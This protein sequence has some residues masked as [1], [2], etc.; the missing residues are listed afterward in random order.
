MRWQP[1]SLPDGAY[2]DASKPFSAQDVVN[3]M[4][5]RAEAANTRSAL[6]LVD[7]PGLREFAILGDGP[8]RGALVINGKAFIVS[9]TTLYKLVSGTEAQIIGTIP[10]RSRVSMTCNQIDGGNE[11]VIAT[12]GDTYV[13]NTLTGDFARVTDSGHHG[14]QVCDYI[15]A[16]VVGVETHRRF[17]QNSAE[18][19]A[20]TYDALET[21]EGESKPDLLVTLIVSENRVVVFSEK[22]VEW[23][24]LSQSQE[25]IDN[26]ILFTNSGV[27]RDR[28]CAGKHALALIDGAVVFLGDD[29]SLYELRGYDP[30]RISTMAVENA[31]ADYDWSKAFATVY[32]DRGHKVFYLTFP[33]GHTWGY[34]FATRKFHRRQSKGMDRWRLNTLFKWDGQWYGGAHNAGTLYTLDWDYMLEGCD[35]H[36]RTVRTGVLHDEGDRVTL[37]AL[38]VEFDSGSE[39]STCSHADEIIPETPPPEVPVEEFGI[40]YVASTTASALA[41]SA[42]FYAIDMATDTIS[43]TGPSGSDAIFAIQA[44]ADGTKLY[45]VDSASL[46]FCSYTHGTDT[47]TSLSSAHNYSGFVLDSTKTYAY[48]RDPLAATNTLY[49]IATATGTVADSD[50]LGSDCAGAMV[51]TADDSKVICFG[52]SSAKVATYDIAAGTVTTKQIGIGVRNRHR[53]AALSVDGTIVYATGDGGLAS[54]WRL[55]AFLVSSLTTTPALSQEGVLPAEAAAVACH[56]NGATVAACNYN[57][58]SG[59]VWIYDTATLTLLTTITVGSKPAGLLYSP[60]GSKL[61]VMNSEGDSVSVIDTESGSATENTVLTTISVPNDPS[62]TATYYVP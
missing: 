46:D 11:I 13:H 44:N 49:K 32:E 61:Y 58:S 53:A 14:F 51:I 24:A 25:D 40:L 2:A 54:G 3:Y 12:G 31:W 45:C 16:K 15:A 6:K 22:S 47:L 30:V 55:Q 36:I 41:P 38:R 50:S 26:H 17:W 48:V 39:E 8:H 52:Y 19:D 56:P 59:A 43:V 28:G 4:A 21:Y 18:A 35:E 60:G 34:D 9:G 20:L 29:G 7:C 5:E 57:N 23:F 33:E 37:N 10:G 1:V 62:G 27:V 42:R